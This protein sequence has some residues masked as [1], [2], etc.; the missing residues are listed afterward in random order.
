MGDLELRN[1]FVD[2]TKEVR[3]EVATVVVAEGGTIDDS[4]SPT[5][6]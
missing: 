4:L 3:Q 6:S 2:S 1:G 5:K